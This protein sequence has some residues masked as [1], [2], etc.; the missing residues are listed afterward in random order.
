M[1]QKTINDE[2]K[3]GFAAIIFAI[4]AALTPVH[5]ALFLSP[6]NTVNK[7][8]AFALMLAIVFRMKSFNKELVYRLI[9]FV[10][11][12]AVTLLWAPS[13]SL[14]NLKTVGSHI[15]LLV[16]CCS[17]VWRK[18]ELDL[19]RKSLVISSVVFSIMLILS[20]MNEEVR[21]STIT[22]GLNEK[23]TDP[24]CLAANIGIGLIF[25]L[26]YIFI[27]RGKLKKILMLACVLVILLGIFSTGSRSALI[28][29]AIASLYFVFSASKKQ[30]LK[31]GSIIG[32]VLG[33][34]LFVFYVFNGGGILGDYVSS[35]NVDTEAVEFGGNG[36][37]E[38]LGQYLAVLA[39]MPL[40][41]LAGYGFPQSSTL[42]SE[43]YMTKWPPATHNDYLYI[44]CSCGIIGLIFAFVFVRYIWKEAKKKANTT[45]MACMV[46]ALI[47][48]VTLNFFDTYGW[49]NA[50]IFAY[51]G[52]LQFEAAN[53]N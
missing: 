40:V 34:A 16:F 33:V 17:T 18:L 39:K 49:W 3:I 28:A 53:E 43:Y 7:Y 24:N 29:V 14:M 52:E 42:Y 15:L 35:R 9:P 47:M 5:Q 13:H 41:A 10:I 51:I 2:N 31:V 12:I 37:I 23:E 50:L 46:L 20:Q 30:R 36:R 21:R 8:I 19:I 48:S 6:G 11:W 1:Q 4:Y 32:L 38:I 26:S 22:F 45:G 27:S 25:A 44:I